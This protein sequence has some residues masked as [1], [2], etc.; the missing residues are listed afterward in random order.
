MRGVDMNNIGHKIV[1]SG[2]CPVIVMHEWLGDHQ[3]Y[4]PILPYLNREDFRWIFIDLRGYGLSKELSG[5]FTCREAA[6]DVVGIADQLE[7]DKFHIVG[8]SMS[9]MIAQRIAADIPKRISTLILV[10]P[11]PA[12]GASLA[13]DAKQSMRSVVY[14]DS[15]AVDAIDA[16]TG[17]RYNRS[18][19]HAKLA[20]ARRSST[21]RARK[22]YLDMFLNTDFS[23]DVVDL[24]VPVRVIVG[25][26]DLPFFK[27]DH[28][29]DTLS[30]W[31]PD[32]Q[33]VNC[34]EAGH[35]PMLECPVFF[36]S[37]L[38]RFVTERKVH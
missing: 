2:A 28:L 34:H 20:I 5:A 25:E 21:M 10:T 9:G 17:Y 37:T 6:D 3:N 23:H 32:M 16:R 30:K 13:D 7:L 8:H 24:D 12:S 19:L 29:K 27:E 38:E 11:V 4:D 15:A 33:I 18:W 1:G 36:A 26:Y 35:Y 22:G 14:D 31:Y